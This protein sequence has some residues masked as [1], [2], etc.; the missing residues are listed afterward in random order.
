MAWN[1]G[2]DLYMIQ[3]SRDFPLCV[4]LVGLSKNLRV[5]VDTT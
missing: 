4:S 2:G 5:V 3:V 1:V